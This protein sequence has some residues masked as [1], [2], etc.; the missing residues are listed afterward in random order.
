MV[1]DCHCHLCDER[2]ADKAALVLEYEKGGVALAINAA[3]NLASCYEGK[4]LADAF[5]SVYFTVGIHPDNP[6]NATEDVLSQILALSLHPK[7]VAIGEIGL[8]YHWTPYDEGLQQRA[9][10]AQIEL[11]KTAKLPFQVHSRDA[12]ADTVKVLS[13]NKDKFDAAL[14][15]CYSGSVETARELLDLGMYFSFSGT[16]TFKNAARLREVAK[17]LPKD[18]ILTETDS[19][20]LAP[21]P[22]RGKENRPL[23]VK[24]VL[25]ALAELKGESVEDMERQVWQN[26]L[27][28]FP[29]IKE[30][31]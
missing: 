28:L 30:R 15:H 2:Y 31:L 19:P 6:Q 25:S 1:V 13:Q 14:M 4:R 22:F 11:A 16:L 9:F 23:Y 29:K 26:T 8:D 21:E 7:A 12:A 3:Y 18:R 20:Y 5:S 17:Y 24:H 10:A 27:T